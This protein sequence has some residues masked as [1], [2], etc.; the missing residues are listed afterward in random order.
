MKILT[1]CPSIYPHKLTNMMDS[2]IIS[3][4]ECTEIRID[5][6]DNGGNITKIF[7]DI[8][9]KNPDFDYYF[10][11][12]DD[13]MFRTLEWDK[14]L[15]KKGRI[16]YGNDTVQGYNLCTFPMIDGD[17]VRALGWLQL[18]TLHRYCGDTVWKFI[19]DN[20]GILDYYSDVIIEHRWEGRDE[21]N[22]TDLAKFAAWLPYSHKD[23]DKIRKAILN[24]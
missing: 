17:I 15:A 24:G 10:M 19:G 14:I 21:V 16:S 4:S 1:I 6:E 13:I 3:K 22:T 8:F 20:L 5:Y 2:F 23:L 12:N 7:N 11:A 9:N 18:P